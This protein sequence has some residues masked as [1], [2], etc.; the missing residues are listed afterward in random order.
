MWL[1]KSSIIP[2]IISIP[3]FHSVPLVQK[4][5]D[6]YCASHESLPSSIQHLRNQNY[7][8]ILDYAMEHK[9]EESIKTRDMILKNIELL[10]PSDMIAIK[11]SS[12]TEKDLEY[13]L[14]YCHDKKQK[15]MIDAEE[16]EH[17]IKMHSYI[18][19][20]QL[21]YNVSDPWLYNTYQC[22]LKN[23][24]EQLKYD[25]EMFKNY[26]VPLGIKLVRGAYLDYEIKTAIERKIPKPVFDNIY[27]TH[28]SYNRSLVHCLKM[29]EY[30]RLNVATHNSRSIHI[31]KKNIKAY[32]SNVT[33]SQ[34]TGMGDDL[35]KSLINDGYMVYKYLPYASYKDMIPYLLRRLKESRIII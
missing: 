24:H 3:Y 16:Y 11:P 33:F 9:K 18:R 20:L 7:G 35:G 13:I 34:L 6:K 26:N 22:Y 10:R 25:I 28:A 8:I 1:L 29:L 12:L 23:T 19:S 15:T 5:Y 4:I 31:A 32:Y 2:K 30:V 17:Q 27:Q 21:T 14:T